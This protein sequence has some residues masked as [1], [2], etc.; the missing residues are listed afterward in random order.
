MLSPRAETVLKSI[1][2]QYIARPV[3]VPSQSVPA[4]CK[5]EVSPA[6]VRNEMVYLEDEGYITRPHPSAGGIPSDKG[7]RHY[8]ESLVDLELPL[9]EQRLITHLFHQV[10]RELEEWL[11]LAA[12]VIAQMTQNVAV[13][14]K[15]KPAGCRFK[16]LE[17]VTLQDSLALVIL[18]LRGAR[19]KQQLITFD[20]VMTQSG[21]TAIATRL[22]D[23]CCDLSMLQIQAKAISLSLPEQQVTDCLL[24][25]MQTEDE[26]QY[27]EP[28]LDGLHFI[29]NQPEFAQA[30]RLRGLIQVVEHRNLLGVIIPQQLAT[31][32]MMV[33][34]GRENEAEV[35]HNCSV[36]I[37][38]YGVR[39]EV[40]G[41]IGVVGPTRMPYAHTIPAVSYLSMVLSYLATELY[42]KK[43]KGADN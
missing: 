4:H 22:N 15:L 13:V 12:A 25:I 31:Q 24:K 17:L 28:Y 19:V 21:L 3:P 6:T 36:V 18:V 29:V 20:Q 41:A 38:Q 26:Q 35:I 40:V 14:T 32:K 8:V 10:E 16:H 5:L 9:V 2:E 27:D 37:S 1:V 23:A 11:R 33:V 7:Y 34:I 30:H 39:D 43:Y 42:E